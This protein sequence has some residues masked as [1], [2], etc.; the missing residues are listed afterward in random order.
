MRHRLVGA[1]LAA[2]LVAAAPAGTAAE[3]PAAYV[4]GIE[5]LP[6]MVG[7]EEVEDAGVT[8]DKPG[9]RIVEAYA[10]GAVGRAAVRGFYADTLPQLG[11]HRSGPDRFRRENEVLELGYLGEDGDLT[12]RFSLQPK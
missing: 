2:A 11:W 12:V 4:A 3:D 7:L 1:A 6:L 10:H 5:D 8:F 9:G